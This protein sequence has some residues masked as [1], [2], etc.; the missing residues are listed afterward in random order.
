MAIW[1][2][3]GTDMPDGISGEAPRFGPNAPP[4]S[5]AWRD[6]ILKVQRHDC[7]AKCHS[8]AGQHI[9][10]CKYGYPRRCH[11]TST[12]LNADTNRYNY[13][14]SLPED[15]RLSPYVPLWAL[16]WGAGMN[17][18][19]CTDAGFLSYISKYV[20]KVRTRCPVRAC[21][22]KR[23]RSMH[24]YPL[25]CLCLRWSPTRTAT[26]HNQPLTGTTNLNELARAPLCCIFFKAESLELRSASSGVSNTQ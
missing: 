17:I 14:C 5:L 7:R 26:N 3:P 8:R 1:V 18:Q 19:R 24:T 13:K 6:F 9:G 21:F 22:R 10:E 11:V 16:A 4:E 2:R 20:T 23:F 15:T 25:F 12:E